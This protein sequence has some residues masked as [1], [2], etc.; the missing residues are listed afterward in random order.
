MGHN[1]PVFANVVST[2]LLLLAVV[3]VVLTRMRLAKPDE[4]GAGRLDIP[5]GLV[6]AHT[7]LGG[8]GIVV[9]GTY[10]FFDVDWVVGF[11]GLLLWWATTVIGLLILLRWLPAKGKHASEGASDEW[12]EGPWLSMLGHLGALVGAI[13][14]SAFVF[15]DKLS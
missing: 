15:A 10:L 14:W 13:V 8:L 5:L 1:D 2:I 12:T 6:N 11:L 3:L 7:V 9:W 4:P